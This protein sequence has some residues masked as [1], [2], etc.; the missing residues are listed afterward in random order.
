M[1]D[2]D[3]IDKFLENFGEIWKHFPDWRFGQLVVN[4]FGRDP[5]YI[6]D[7]T[8]VKMMEDVLKQIEEQM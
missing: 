6:E 7:D 2:P 5:F 4:M 3:R 8:G 1:R